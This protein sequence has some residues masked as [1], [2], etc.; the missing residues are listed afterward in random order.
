[1]SSWLRSSPL[2]QSFNRGR[3]QASP[4]TDFD[5]K[6][7]IDSF[8]RHWQQAYEIIGRSEV[9]LVTVINLLLVIIVNLI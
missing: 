2:R 1:M 3:A 6:A 5:E 8:C 7:V 9:S 4:L